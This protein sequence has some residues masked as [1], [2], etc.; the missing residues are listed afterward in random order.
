MELTHLEGSGC[1]AG[2]Q[3]ADWNDYAGA[4]PHLKFGRMVRINL[5][6]HWLA[7]VLRALRMD[8]AYPS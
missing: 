7:S 5:V 1:S 2:V 4:R 6:C 3:H 8:L